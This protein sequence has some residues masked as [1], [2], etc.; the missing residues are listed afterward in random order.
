MIQAIIG[1]VE[2]ICHCKFQLRYDE[3]SIRGPS[4]DALLRGGRKLKIRKGEY[5]ADRRA[6]APLR[7]KL[8]HHTGE[9]RT[10]GSGTIKTN[11]SYRHD[12]ILLI[13]TDHHSSTIKIQQVRVSQSKYTFNRHSV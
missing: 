10:A 13:V 6:I 3:N 4:S 9:K 12:I 8:S 2:I 11:Y 5:I 1:K 7:V